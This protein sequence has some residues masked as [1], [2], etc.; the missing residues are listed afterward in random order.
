MS[1]IIKSDSNI[2]IYHLQKCIYMKKMKKIFI[3]FC[4]L[5]AII[6]ALTYGINRHIINTEKKNI[7]AKVTTNENILEKTEIDQSKNFKGDCIMVLGCG[8]KDRE[9]PSPMLKDRLDVA[10]LLY[11]NG[12]A[13]KILM[14][15]DNGTVSHNEIHVMLN[16]ALK[17]GI[18]KKDIFCDHAGFSTYESMYRGK[19][20]FKIDKMIVIT[21]TYH[22]YRSLYIANKLG[23]KAIGVSAD[24]EQYSGKFGRE[25][26]EIFAR[27]KDY[28][29]SFYKP[30]PTF[31]GEEI[32]ITGSG[33]S[34]HGE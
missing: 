6:I 30:K 19:S 32:P 16:Y 27:V 24:Q 11:R 20:I 12:A 25:S 31:G 9:T 2:K 14:T 18:P 33:V 22:M 29:Q 10:I 21:Q 26:R 5:A 8:I 34:S 4:L 23:I 3:L 17:Q 7:V 15:G 28:F 13:P 1:L